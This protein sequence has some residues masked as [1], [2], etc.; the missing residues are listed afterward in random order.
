MNIISYALGSLAYVEW[1]Y[2][3]GERALRLAEVALQNYEEVLKAFPDDSHT[4][5]NYAILLETV[6]LNMLGAEKYYLLSLSANPKYERGLINYAD[7]LYQKLRQPEKAELWFQKL[8]EY[9]PN[10]TTGIIH[11]AT[12]LRVNQNKTRSA[13]QLL[14]KREKDREMERERERK[15]RE[16][17]LIKNGFVNCNN[18]NSNN[19]NDD[20]NDAEVKKELAFLYETFLHDNELA[21]TYYEKAIELAPNN[22]IINIYIIYIY[23]Y[24]VIFIY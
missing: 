14:K 4:L 21:R 22:V 16:K 18:N 24:I 1:L 7:F 15:E 9:H 19:S 23:K 2:S 12:F 5:Q 10:N 6:S 20:N 8:L 17:M 11:Y 3:S 13:F